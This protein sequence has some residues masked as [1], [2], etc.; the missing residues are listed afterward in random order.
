MFRYR[1]SLMAAALAVLFALLA[2]GE[3]G[4]L[5]DGTYYDA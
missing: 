5:A 1:Y 3:G 4:A 2:S